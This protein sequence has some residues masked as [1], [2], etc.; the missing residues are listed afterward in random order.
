MN[1]LL[2]LTTVLGTLAACEAYAPQN[3]DYEFHATFNRGTAHRDAS[4]DAC[5]ILAAFD[6]RERQGLDIPP[7][8]VKDWVTNISGSC[9]HCHP[10]VAEL[11]EIPQ[12]AEC[13]N[14]NSPV[15]EHEQ[16]R[17]YRYG[18]HQP[19]EQTQQ[20]GCTGGQCHSVEHTQFAFYSGPV[21]TDDTDLPTPPPNPHTQAPLVDIFPL[22]GGHVGQSCADS[23]CHEAGQEAAAA[24]KSEYC[25]SCHGRV[26]D[27]APDGADHY[28]PQREGWTEERERDCLA[29]HATIELQGAINYPTSWGTD[30]AYD[31]SYPRNHVFLAPH[32]TVEAWG[33]TPL[34]ARAEPAWK[35]QCW[36]C[37]NDWSVSQDTNPAD[38]QDGS[39]QDV[40]PDPLYMALGD[41]ERENCTDG[42]HAQIDGVANVQH[43]GGQDCL[44][45]GCHT[46]AG[47]DD[48]ASGP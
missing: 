29:C 24:G 45:S 31:P 5:H 6:Q 32:N 9:N 38:T 19:F 26:R 4:C 39:S 18:G 48:V 35:R 1:R 20:Q 21:D 41:V 40:V 34:V 43:G 2:A 15:Y 11:G 3:P 28:P 23:T 22:E 16:C 30:A 10:F 17:F 27:A 42:C 37:H 25:G 12:L 46:T 47:P 44:S 7:P 36:S 8:D 14:P 13:Q 33:I